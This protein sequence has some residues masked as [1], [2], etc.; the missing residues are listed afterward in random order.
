MVARYAS[1]FVFFP[2]GFGTLDELFEIATLLQTRTLR[3]LPVVLAR[4]SYWGPLRAWLRET[5]LAEGL[6]DPGDLELLEPA[7]D[8]AEICAR[9]TAVAGRI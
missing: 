8:A 1:A 3:P 2:G 6:I 5:V 7:D 9:V 4:S